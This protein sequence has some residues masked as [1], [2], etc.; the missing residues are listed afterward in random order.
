MSE[1]YGSKPSMK[2][3]NRVAGLKNAERASQRT[4]ATGNPCCRRRLSRQM[5]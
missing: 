5:A 2:R 1:P 4:N 3:E